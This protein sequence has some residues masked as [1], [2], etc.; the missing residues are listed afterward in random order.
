[1]SVHRPSLAWMHRLSELFAE[2][3]RRQAK[4]IQQHLGIKVD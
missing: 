3:S 4:V 1:M 2:T